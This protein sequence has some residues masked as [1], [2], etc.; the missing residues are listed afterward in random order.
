MKWFNEPS[1]KFGKKTSDHCIYFIDV[2]KNRG[3]GKTEE[4]ER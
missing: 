3:K 4:C 1:L 2:I